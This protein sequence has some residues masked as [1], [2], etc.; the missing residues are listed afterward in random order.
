M[1]TGVGGE[2]GDSRCLLVAELTC[3]EHQADVQSMAERQVKN[4]SWDCGFCS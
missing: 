1:I 3:S 4:E 2:K